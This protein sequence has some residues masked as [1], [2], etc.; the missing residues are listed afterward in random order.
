MG[1]V[2][3]GDPAMKVW[4]LPSGWLAGAV[5]A[6]AVIDVVGFGS[7]SKPFLA[8]FEDVARQ[9][10]I[11]SPTIF[12]GRSENRYIIETTGCGAAF[13]DYDSDGWPDILLVNGS[14]LEGVLSPP[15]TNR[16]LRNK[17]DGT[18]LDVTGI[19]GLAKAGWGQGVCAGDYDNDGFED[20]YVT[21][22]GRN[23]L[24]HNNGGET[25]TE[26]TDKTG[27]SVKQGGWGAGCAFLDYDRDGHLDLFYTNYIDFDLKTAPPT[28]QWFMR[29]SGVA[30]Q[31]RP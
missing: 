15:P 31:L 25:F 26:V 4:A 3:A 28:W 27:L 22:W 20:L 24:Y 1:A 13:F 7:S 19:T 14:V 23:I 21:Y 8:R 30:C 9:A 16:L 12:G 29:L 6:F 2:R 5:L 17:R 18:F 11:T 10:G